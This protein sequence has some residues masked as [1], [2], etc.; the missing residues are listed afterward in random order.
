MCSSGSL[1]RKASQ[2]LTTQPS[3]KGWLCSRAQRSSAPY[4]SGRRARGAGGLIQRHFL[5]CPFPRTRRLR[6][7]ACGFF[8]CDGD[9]KTWETRE[10]DAGG[11]GLRAGREWTRLVFLSAE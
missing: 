10:A 2:A 9:A 3:G 7:Y 6:R 8:R 5:A 4:R 1:V 11:Q